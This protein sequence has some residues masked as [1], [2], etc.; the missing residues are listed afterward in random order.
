[1]YLALGIL[2]VLT[3][4]GFM[5]KKYSCI[6]C[7][8][9]ISG[10][11]WLV[12][13]L[14]TL[15]MNFDY[16][17]DYSIVYCSFAL[18][19]LFFS[20]GF[21]ISDKTRLKKN[22]ITYIHTFKNNVNKWILVVSYLVF[23]LAIYSV[24]D[25]IT[26]YNP[27]VIWQNIKRIEELPYFF[28]AS[29]SILTVYSLIVFTVYLKKQTTL[30]YFI[31][32]IIPTTGLLLA[33][34][35]TIWFITIVFF[36]FAFLYIKKIKASKIIRLFIM[37]SV[38][39]LIVFW[40]SSSTKY[41]D[42]MGN[43]NSIEQLKFYIYEYF[44]T[45][46][47]AFVKWYSSFDK[48]YTYG[49]HIFRFFISLY[50]KV[51]GNVDVPSTVMDF[52]KVNGYDTNVYTS[53]HWY[54][55]DFG[56]IGTYVI[57]FILGFCFGYLYGRYLKNKSNILSVLLISMFSACIIG[58]FYAE[59]L[60]TQASAWIQRIIA[61]LVLYKLLFNNSRVTYFK[62]VELINLLDDSQHLHINEE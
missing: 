1:M 51:N 13:Y 18:S 12:A 21:V 28:G 39:V 49:T 40:L 3:I 53:L 57:F 37:M 7:P 31:L 29:L 14:I 50:S 36:I 56:L 22:N 55:L 62:Q 42:V 43:T 5:I 48:Q 52:I 46:M 44:A 9:V 33:S 34:S 2:L 27:F 35:R 61:L 38:T 45:P 6:Y 26:S 32:S 58:Q 8:V 54:T 47:Q 41:S 19:Y 20:I 25:C 60:F 23:I 11:V 24:K 30:F 4:M 15:L 16:Q 10:I 17:V 59:Q